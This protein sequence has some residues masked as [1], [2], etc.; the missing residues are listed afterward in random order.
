MFC[1]GGYDGDN[2][3]W[4]INNYSIKGGKCDSIHYHMCEYIL[5]VIMILYAISLRFNILMIID[6]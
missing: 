5:F 2:V 4:I 6:N 1:V 3:G